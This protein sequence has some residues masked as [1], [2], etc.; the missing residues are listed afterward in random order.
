[1]PA[2]PAGAGGNTLAVLA[3]QSGSRLDRDTASLVTDSIRKEIGASGRFLVLEQNRMS[4]TGRDRATKF[5]RCA[6]KD[7]AVEAGKML[8][9]D[10]VVIGTLTRSGRT[11]YLS[12]S[13]VDVG[14]QA[15]VTVVEERGTGEAE[16]LNQMSRTAVKRLLGS[17]LPAPQRDAESRNER[18]VVHETAVFDRETK[19]TWL[20]SPD[21]EGKA[22]TW[23]EARD[24]IQ[25]LSRTRSTVYDN[26]RLPDK[27]ELSTLQAYANGRGVKMNLHELFTRI[28]FRNIRADY[29]WSATSSD[30]M[31][32]LAWVMDLYGGEMSLA[33]KNGKGYAWPVRTGPWLFEEPSVGQ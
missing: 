27:D 15:I 25:R 13:Q 16:A 33:D 31:P 22:M 17:G 29:Y 7:C 8:G 12:L 5:L 19:L 11:Y 30:D 10:T 21:D 23:D 4:L 18:F 26:W 24:Y 20:R 6:A 28:G 9:V 14:T 1:M 3:V 32:G 2:G